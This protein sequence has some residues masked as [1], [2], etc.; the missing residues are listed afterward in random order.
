MYAYTHPCIHLPSQRHGEVKEMPRLTPWTAELGTRTKDLKEAHTSLTAIVQEIIKRGF[1]M[2]GEGKGRREQVYTCCILPCP[3]HQD[4]WSEEIAKWDQA[5]DIAGVPEVRD[6][7][8]HMHERRVSPPPPGQ[9]GGPG[10]QRVQGEIRG[11]SL[12]ADLPCPSVPCPLI[13]SILQL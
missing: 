3:S 8:L 10:P 9:S 1:E 12:G 13:L 11:G 2:R 7:L 4:T 6:L 5:F